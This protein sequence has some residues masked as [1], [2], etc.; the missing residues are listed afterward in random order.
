MEKTYQSLDHF[1]YETGLRKIEGKR[2]DEYFKE[3]QKREDSL[4]LSK[5][6]RVLIN[7]WEFTS[8]ILQAKPGESIVVD[9]DSGKLF[10]GKV[11]KKNLIPLE[12]KL[13]G[14]TSLEIDGDGRNEFLIGKSWAFGHTSPTKKKWDGSVK[15][16]DKSRSH[17][18][19]ALFEEHL[20]EVSKEMVTTNIRQ[21]ANQV[22][23]EISIKDWP[24]SICTSKSGKARYYI[25]EGKIYNI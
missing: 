8:L 23:T 22:Y 19:V 7:L 3:K 20:R 6:S 21:E 13:P 15:L 18:V 12:E 11:D 24:V 9:C 14:R 1:L 25:F 16:A 10:R 4:K 17:P 5:I 2:V